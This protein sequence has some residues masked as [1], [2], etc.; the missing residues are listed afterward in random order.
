MSVDTTVYL[1]G[2]NVSYFF[3]NII[4]KKYKIT[5]IDERRGISRVYIEIHKHGF[6]PISV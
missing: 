6:K 1:Y 2:K 4:Q 3:Y 5:L